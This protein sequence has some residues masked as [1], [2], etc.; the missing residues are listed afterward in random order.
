MYRVRSGTAASSLWA[1][2]PPPPKTTN[3]PLSRPPPV[4][5]TFSPS[6]LFLHLAIEP[7]AASAPSG[8][9]LCGSGA[10]RCGSART[11]SGSGVLSPG[12]APPMLC[13]VLWRR[14]RAGSPYSRARHLGLSSLCGRCYSCGGGSCLLRCFGL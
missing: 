14:A 5:T 7:L 9:R 4:G 3:C 10:P 11:F 13:P 1:T 8:R 2:P 6:S 12:C